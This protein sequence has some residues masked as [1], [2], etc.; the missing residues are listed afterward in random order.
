LDRE[1]LQRIFDEQIEKMYKLIDEQ[2]KRLQMSHA[3]ETIVR[4]KYERTDNWLTDV[5]S[6][7]LSCLVDWGARHMY[8]NASKPAMKAVQV[9]SSRT[10]KT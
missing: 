4:Q 3:R 9:A 5:C 10:P 2:L 8:A 6:L 1:E 7:I